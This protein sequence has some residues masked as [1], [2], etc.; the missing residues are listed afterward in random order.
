MIPINDRNRQILQMRSDGVPR[1]EVARRFQLWPR[2]I[3]NI[4]QAAKAVALVA[5]RRAT[6][7]ARICNA[8]DPD[9]MWPV[10]DLVDALGLI[11]GTRRRLLNYF[12]GQGICQISL[13]NLMDMCS[14]QGEFTMPPLLQVHGIKQIGFWS[15]VNGLTNLS[16]GDRC[17]KEWRNI[18]AQVK[19][20]WRIAGPTP[21]SSVGM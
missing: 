4:E 5:E 12:S 15:V 13:R 18:L 17:N 16:L 2:S 19:Q 9:R 3:S 7:R 10:M 21:Y 11:M 14:A 20:E 1:N 8:D 6:L